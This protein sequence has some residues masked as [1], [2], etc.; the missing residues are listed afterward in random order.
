MRE[1]PNLKLDDIMEKTQQKWNLGINK[2]LAYRENTMT[3][4]IVDESFKEQYKRIHDYAHELLRSNTRSTVKVTSQEIQGGEENIDQ[5]NIPLNPYFQRMYICFKAY[6]DSFFK[7]RPII[8]LDGCF[9][10]GYYGGKI[11]EAIGR[12]P[13]D[14]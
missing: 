3:I 11:I 12:D 14:Q 6:S 5:P 1:N 13:N 2:T 8:G 9:L 7:C 4:D 10:K